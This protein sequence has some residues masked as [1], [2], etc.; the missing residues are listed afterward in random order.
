MRAL[1]PLLMFLD[2]GWEHVDVLHHARPGAA[3]WTGAG[4]QRLV[5]AEEIAGAPA[6]GVRAQRVEVLLSRVGAPRQRLQPGFAPVLESRH[7]RERALLGRRVGE[8]KDAAGAEQERRL[9][10][11]IP[12]QPWSGEHETL[13]LRRIEADTIG[14]HPQIR[15]VPELGEG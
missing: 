6:E 5:P 3:V 15:H 4:W 12:V 11:D 8:I 7:D 14:G 13:P 1:N 2:P 10:A 9:D